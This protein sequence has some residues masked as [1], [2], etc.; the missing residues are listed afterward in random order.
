MGAIET[1]V[2]GG[3]GII[4]LADSA[5]GNRLNSSSLQQLEEVVGQFA[6]DESVRVIL[7]RS[8][9]ENFC[10]GMDLGAVQE[11]GGSEDDSR[12]PVAAYS[13]LLQQLHNLAKP[14]VAA[15]GGAVKAGGVGLTAACDIVLASESA[16]WQLSEVLL[17]LV[18]VN[19]LPFLF[20]R[21]IPEQKVRY[22]VLTAKTVSA[23]EA[24]M[25]G[26]ADEVYQIE[27]FERGIKQVLKM[28]F[29]AAPQALAATKRITADLSGMGLEDSCAYAQRELVKLI[30]SAEVQHG[31]A[32]FNDGELPEWSTGFKTKLPLA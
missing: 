8:N 2:D 13:R 23:T 17:G 10:L 19:V 21:R 3:L 1:A 28:L 14:V 22:L 9:G 20:Q 24:R 11:G 6:A 32:A 27:K 12:G 18:P 16:T 5:N 7:F 30:A 26:I 15:V 4:T 29:R 25:L 31:V